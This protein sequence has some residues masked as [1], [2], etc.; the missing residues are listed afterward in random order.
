MSAIPGSGGLQGGSSGGAP[1][2]PHPY[3]TQ[4]LILLMS[5]KSHLS[6]RI[7]G[8]IGRAGTRI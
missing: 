5:R 8:D 2:A 1:Q 4:A 3:L 6:E 7:L